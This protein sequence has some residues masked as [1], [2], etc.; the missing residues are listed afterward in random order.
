[1]K[2]ENRLKK[3]KT[4]TLQANKKLLFKIIIKVEKYSRHL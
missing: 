1:M 4:E 3:K 2:W